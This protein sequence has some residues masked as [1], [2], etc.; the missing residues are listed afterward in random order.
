ML[1]CNFPAHRMPHN[2]CLELMAFYSDNYRKR[3]LT[4]LK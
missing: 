4:N 2:V 1:N 3:V